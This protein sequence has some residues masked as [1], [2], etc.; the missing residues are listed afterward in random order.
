VKP[1][2]LVSRWIRPEVRALSAYS[3]QEAAGLIKLDAMENPYGWPEALRRE[4]A[5]RL[6]RIDVNRYPDPQARE[7]VKVLRQVA[8]IPD[9][10]EVLLGNG[11]DEIIQIIALAL[12]GAGRT[13][14]SVEP[15]FVMYR[16]IATFCGLEYVGV[17][18]REDFSLDMPALRAAMAMH[19]PAVI[20]LACPNNP[21]GN[22]FDEA[23]LLEIIER[24]PGLV[25][26]DEAYQPFTD[27]TFM[28]RLGAFPNLLVMRTLS[29]L[30]LAGLRLGYLTGPKAWLEE[31][32]KVRMPY[33]INI[34]TQAATRFIL[35]RHQVLDR[36]TATIRQERTRLF[37]ALEVLEGFTPCPSEANFILV[38][39]RSGEAGAVFERLKQG[40]VLVKNLHG[41][42]P[43]L[44][45]CLRFTV[46]AP[47][48]NQ[49][50]L[51]L[52][53]DSA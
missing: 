29:K 45:D 40:G 16:M 4:W 7:L 53:R 33:N 24:A 15:G 37:G 34:L 28:G 48:E 26:I 5:E 35:E 2:I 32:H 10:M 42:H 38:R 13:I 49:K 43:L 3:V 18:L 27:A 46:G 9:D 6:A 52:L 20:F 44:E 19:Q 50:L 12:G 51:S 11:S 31:L 1:E 22:L 39:T 14:L 8:G 17:P 47:E 25:V 36:Q 23:D 41:S 21:T 30:G